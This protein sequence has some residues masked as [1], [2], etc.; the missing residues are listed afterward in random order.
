MPV[1]EYKATDAS[2]K[3]VTG[4]AHGA[5]LI[6]V[7]SNLQ[8]K[9]LT[10]QSVQQHQSL[11]DIPVQPST[12]KKS[13]PADQAQTAAASATP[14][15]QPK[16]LPPLEARSII[17]KDIMGP[18]VGKVPLRDLYFYFKQLAT[19]LSAGVGMI[20]SMNTLANQSRSPK[21]RGIIREMA[22]HVEAGR[23]MSAGMQRYPEVFNPLMMSMIRTGE[24]LGT[25]D[26]SSDMLASYLEQE[27]ELRRL[28]SRETMYPKIVIVASIIIIIAA[29]AVIKSVGG[30][31]QLWSPLTE[32]RTWYWLGPLIVFLFL[33]IRIGLQN[34]RIKFN[35]DILIACIPGF[36]SVARK[37]AMAKFGR[38]F[39]AMYKGGVS[40]PEAITLG[41]DACGNEYIRSR[42]YP[43]VRHLEA[44]KP[45]TQT[46]RETGIFNP[47]VIDMTQ[48]GEMTGSLDQMLLKVSE[49]YEG[50]AAVQARRNALI[51]GVVVFLCVAVY[52]LILLIK[53]YTG[54]FQNTFKAA[55][56]D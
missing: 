17:A 40:I 45:I 8:T 50:E 28:I 4:T 29:N 37:F 56:G 48:T 22:G 18:V 46:F 39:G 9:G 11:D 19:M 31:M 26:S 6:A 2:G 20:Q 7:T 47:I 23:P 55:G 13:A 25:L 15:E 30:G 1:Y 35:W 41:A 38:A 49:F 33:F 5:D 53:F 51:F 27:M 3:V 34:N 36:A 54:Y 42:I 21:L 52:V 44:G 14:P 32:I 16:D 10:V 24:R 43:A 12:E